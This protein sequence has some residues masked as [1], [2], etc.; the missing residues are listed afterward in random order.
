M[1]TLTH[2]HI[3]FHRVFLGCGIEKVRFRDIDCRHWCTWIPTN[4]YN[5]DVYEL[6]DLIL[7]RAGHFETWSFFE[8][9]VSRRVCVFLLLDDDGSDREIEAAGALYG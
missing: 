5:V 6:K 1:A 4:Q 2:K 7:K 3:T 9:C 8:R